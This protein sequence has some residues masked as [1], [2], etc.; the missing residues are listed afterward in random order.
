M[1]AVALLIA[2]LLTAPCFAANEKDP[3]TP[4]PPNKAAPAKP[5]KW[6][7]SH[8]WLNAIERVRLLPKPGEILNSSIRAG[9]DDIIEVPAPSSEKIDKIVAA[10]D[11]E[12]VKLPAKWEAEIKAL[13]ANYEAQIIAE[14]PAEKREAAK[15]LLDYSHE[16]S[17]NN[18]GREQKFMDDLHAKIGEYRGQHKDASPEQQ[19]E[20]T[21]LLN[22]WV[23]EER[24]KINKEDEDVIEGLRQPLTPDEVQRLDKFNRRRP[25]ESAQQPGPEKK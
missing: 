8:A 15:K 12:V 7:L 6:D 19:Q 2:M 22:Q 16:N 23:K 9:V 25:A 13:R 24:N 14:L 5:D 21:G 10:Y 18:I 11:A 17:A 3:P 1:R 4:A 20:A